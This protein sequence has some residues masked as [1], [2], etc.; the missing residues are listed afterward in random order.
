EVAALEAKLTSDPDVVAVTSY[1]GT[2][3]PR[4]YLP[5]DVQTPN[6]NLGEMM[7]MTKGGAARERVLAKIQTLFENDF[8]LVR[9]RVNRLENGPPVGYPVQ[10][11]VFGA[12]NR[13]VQA[14]ADQ[15]SAILR[16]DPHIRRVNQDWGERLKRLKVDVDQD[17]ARALGLTS[18]EIQT[19]LQGSLS[20]TTVTQY[21]EG[22]D[23]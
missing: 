20:G 14:V 23:D 1:V 22:D 9:G 10:F 12:D 6:L 13:Q 7:V 21:R 8:P 19:A 15:V 3:S 4:F 16:A 11:R 18:R 2:G 17:K 5:L